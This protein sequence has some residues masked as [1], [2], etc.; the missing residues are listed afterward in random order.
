MDVVSFVD[1]RAEMDGSIAC[2]RY[3][4]SVVNF[5]LFHFSCANG[6]AL[7]SAAQ[8][9]DFC[10]YTFQNSPDFG[11]ILGQRDLRLRGPVPGC[12]VSTC[13][14]C[15]DSNPGARTE[16]NSARAALLNLVL[17][18][19]LPSHSFSGKLRSRPV[20]AARWRAS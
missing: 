19:E 17:N 14:T 1:D 9:N 18:Y 2:S 10:A 13:S 12:L 4:F 3:G 5:V 8:A 20:C 7:L 6:R 11:D 15:R 16:K